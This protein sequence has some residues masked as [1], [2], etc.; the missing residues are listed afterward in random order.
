M[1]APTTGPNMVPRPP[2][3]VISTTSPT[4]PSARRS[5]SELE[6]DRLGAARKS[7]QG[8]GEDEGDQLVL[9][10]LVAE[11]GGAFRFR[12][13][14]STPVQRRVD[15]TV[16]QQEAAQED[17]EHDEVERQ[18]IFQIENAEHHAAR[19]AW[20]PSSPPVKGAC[21]Q[22]KNSI[23]ARARVIMAK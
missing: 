16:D 8:C 7:G 12:G 1:A 4:C 9:I 22:K 15:S 17:A 18:R 21:R 10:G 13:S 2:S 19:I 20:M 14:P 3:S 6:D 23:C 11:R 5:V